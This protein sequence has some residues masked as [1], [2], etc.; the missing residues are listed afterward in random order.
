MFNDLKHLS[1]E[2]VNRLMERY[3]DGENVKKLI[4]E[5]NINVAPNCLVKLFPPLKVDNYLCEYCKTNLVMERL[6]KSFKYIERHESE[7]YCP[8]CYHRPYIKNCQCKNC[9]EKAEKIKKEKEEKLKIYFSNV[10]APVEF[11]TI[12][13][14]NKVYLGALCRALLKEN[15]YEICPYVKVNIKITPL[16][17]FLINIYRNLSKARIIV[18]SPLSDIN[19]FVWNKEGIPNEYYIEEVEYYLNLS[20]GEEKYDMF[21]KILNP[22]YYNNSL[23]GEGFY[24]WKKIAVEECIEYLLYQ[25]RKVSFEFS[26]GEKTYKTFEM[27]LNDFSVSQIYGIIWKSVSEASRLYLEK[28]MT[29]KHAANSVIGACER[30]ADRA[31]INKWNLVSYNRIP[32]LPQ[33]I[34]SEFFFYKVLKIGDKG[35]Y[36]VPQIL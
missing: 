15:L 19:A 14:E 5:Y 2:D 25:L 18:V 10:Y 12:S 34:L 24:L 36:S 32:D 28:R 3:Y 4:K 22:D 23:A 29:K 27:I 17:G 9:L 35:F 11:D 31:K 16:K 30:Y 1:Q 13:F 33:S 21:N 7:F 8:N 26:P 20:F 6:S